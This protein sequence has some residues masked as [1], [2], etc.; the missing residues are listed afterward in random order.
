VDSNTGSPRSYIGYFTAECSLNEILESN[1]LF[2]QKPNV[3]GVLISPSPAR[4]ETSCACQKCD[5]QKNGLIWL[6]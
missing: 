2:P 3:T 6:G 5:R 4:N 1:S